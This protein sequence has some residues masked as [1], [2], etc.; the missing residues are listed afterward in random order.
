M[1]IEVE[2]FDTVAAAARWSGDDLGRQA[3][4]SLFDRLD[5]F[6][7]TEATFPG[8][9]LIL[10]ARSAGSRAWLFLRQLERRAEPLGSWYTLRFAPV[11][12]GEP[13]PA[14]QAALLTAI[15]RRL[16]GRCAWLSLSPLDTP[17]CRSLG[18]ALRSAGWWVREAVTSANWTEHSSRLDWESYWQARP[19]R[20]RSTVRRAQRRAP[21][22][23]RIVSQFDDHRWADYKEVFGRSWKPAEGSWQ[24]LEHLARQEGKA[25]TLRLGLGYRDGRPVAAQL[26]LVENGTAT[27]HKLAHD[28]ACDSFSPGSQL[29]AAMFRHVLTHDRPERI[30]FGTGDEPYKA[31]WVGERQPL[32]TL[33][34]VDPTTAVGLVRAARWQVARLV[35]R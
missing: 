23:T 35:R 9:S 13:G 17:A 24:F 4:P 20:L 12:A 1:A 7:L 27:I 25:G 28:Q 10:G 3:Q 6:R 30:D 15:T 31:D 8:D 2:L 22:D 19:S 5:W 18:A 33:E 21:T 26:W 29:S 34:A 14:E 32:Y 16:R 11:F